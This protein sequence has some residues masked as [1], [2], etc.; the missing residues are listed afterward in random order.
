[1]TTSI[2]TITTTG[3]PGLTMTQFN[4][5]T[6][7]QQSAISANGIASLQAWAFSDTSFTTVIGTGQ[8]SDS[9]LPLPATDARVEEYQAEIAQQQLF[10]RITAQYNSAIASGAN[11]TS[12]SNPGLNGN[13]SVN[14]AAI[15]NIQAEQVSILTG[16]TFTTGQ[17]SRVWL[18]SS[19]IPV[20]FPTTAEFTTFA[21]AIALFVN[22]L[23]MALAA[24]QQSGTF[25]APS[26]SIT[27]E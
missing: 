26:N 2:Q 17:T 4:A 5:L 10:Q 1:M 6:S 7:D 9:W 8:H 16:G 15:A 25:T 3:I 22:N 23:I 24:A 27:I 19:G 20:T 21:K 12:T 13:Y 18:L 14:S 11:V